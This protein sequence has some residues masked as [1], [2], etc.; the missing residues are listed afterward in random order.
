MSNSN[1]NMT[2]PYQVLD[3]DSIIEEIQ[4]LALDIFASIRCE[5]NQKTPEK[6]ENYIKNAINLQKDTS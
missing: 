4:P 1:S 3:R 5:G 2:S 6:V